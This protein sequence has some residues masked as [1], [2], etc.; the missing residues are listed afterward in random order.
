MEA[1]NHRYEHYFYWL[2]FLIALGLRIFRLGAAPL[3]DSEASWAL[4]ALHLAHGGVSTVLGAQP[5]YILITSILFS[6]LDNTNFLARFIPALT[7]S[8]IIWLPFY[9]RRWMGDS[10]W[11]HRAGLV[12]AFGL[13]I[14]PGL[15]ALSRQAGSL[16]PALVFT[17]LALAAVYNRRMLWLGIFAG[18]A[19]LSGPAFL[20]GLLILA[21]SWGLLRLV[22]GKT[23]QAQEGMDEA[24]PPVEFTQPFH[25]QKALPAFVL[26]ILIAGTLFLRAPQGLGGL[27]D[28][29]SAY[30]KTWIT[31]SGIP[32][33]RL[34]GSLLVY[35]IFVIIFFLI[36]FI[37]TWFSK[38]VDH[39]I[40][41]AMMGLSIWSIV[42]FLLPL[43][44]VGR[45]VGD[46]AWA[47]VPLWALA[48]LE[49]GR[50][51]DFGDDKTTHVVAACLAALLLVLAVVGW[52]NFL[53]ISHDASRLVLYLAIMIGAFLLGLIAVLLVA[54]GWSTHAA[55]LGVVAALCLVFG[56]QLISNTIGM[57]IVRRGG[58]QELWSTASTTGQ[59]DLLKSTLTDLSARTTGMRDQLEIVALNASPS[60]EW[61]LRNFPNA[62][63][64]STLASTEAPPVVITLKGAEEPVLAEKYRGQDFVWTLSP[65]WL[66]AFPPDFVNWLAFRTAPL[67]QTQVI[68]WAR[69]D[70]FPGGA[71]ENTSATAP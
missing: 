35:E 49:I 6:L 3:A 67:N 52:M 55:R 23:D 12:L 65:A 24:E 22:V 50:F 44:Y 43:V 38:N 30:L 70:I 32:I 19:L 68:L 9:F 27:A 2:A 51:L 63:F 1:N 34:P 48:S 39:F 60:L 25:I 58:A 18:L 40:H 29:L 41:P 4:Q 21:V 61:A 20:Q 8:L 36:A 17:L 14:D 62:R 57:A 71:L 45:Q 16:M 7:G 5:A 42:A 69:A 28:T 31:P 10:S 64:E 47:L 46:M 54:A 37:R 26:T 11:L 33:L 59:A 66:G 56:L 15:V 13:A 53:S